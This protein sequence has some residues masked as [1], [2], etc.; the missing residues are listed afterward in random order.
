[1]QSEEATPASKL[2]IQS[3]GFDNL[4]TERLVVGVEALKERY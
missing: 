4:R 1:M 3:V 2:A